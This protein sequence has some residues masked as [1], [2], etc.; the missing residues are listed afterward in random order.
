MS[1]QTDNVQNLLQAF[2]L[3]GEEVEVY[4][5]LLTKSPQS[6]LELSK[7]LYKG[8]TKIYRL[9]ELLNEKGL[10]NTLVDD[11][12]KKFEA[13]SVRQ[14]ELLL[15]EKESELEKLKT[16]S[17]QVFET[18]ESLKPTLIGETKIKYYKGKEGLK[19]VTWNTLRAKG[20]FRIYEINLMHAFL[21]HDF[22]EKVR[23][24]FALRRILVHQLT[25]H[26]TFE[27]YTD[28]AQHVKDW[29]L[30]YIDPSKLSIS[31]ETAVYNDVYVLYSFEGEDVFC[32]EL[33]NQ[34]LAAMQKQIFDLIFEYAHPMKILNNHGEAKLVA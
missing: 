16:Q 28:V 15:K 20:I 22:S 7:N 32:V 31:I 11:V 14:L 13:N 18:L 29:T 1:L 17:M 25:N 10:V 4:M 33:Y 26:K 3:S 21:D 27:P 19:Q 6:A 2:G 5:A 9:L 34:K 24:E 12:G 23:A 30:K 8:R